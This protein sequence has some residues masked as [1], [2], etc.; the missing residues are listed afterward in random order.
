MLDFA[1]LYDEYARD[2]RRFA[3][4]LSGDATVADDITSET[5]IRA[6]GAKDRFDL[7]SVRGYLFAIARNL[8]LHLLRR[9]RT[10]P[11]APLGEED[12]REIATGEAS[13]ERRATARSELA[14]VLAELQKLPEVDRAALLMRAEDQLPYDEIA[15]VLDL[16]L[17]AT[18]VKIHRARLRLAEAR[19]GSPTTETPQ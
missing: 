5:F 14:R 6:W 4:F 10:R 13:P 1:T 7:A 11:T 15:R 8:H 16:T 2:V 18:K 12:S 19:L 9:E 17:S 3:L